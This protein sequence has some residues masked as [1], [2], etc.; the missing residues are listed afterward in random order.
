VRV[1]TGEAVRYDDDADSAA[2]GQLRGNAGS[3]GSKSRSTD[4][5]RSSQSTHMVR[6]CIGA[7]RRIRLG[8]LWMD[9]DDAP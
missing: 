2:G 3:L 1:V 5:A 8:M 6:A 9:G 4:R 7:P